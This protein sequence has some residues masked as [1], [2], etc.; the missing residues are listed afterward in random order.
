LTDAPRLR[1]LE[2]PEAILLSRLQTTIQAKR[3]DSGFF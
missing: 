3:I 2:K 1:V